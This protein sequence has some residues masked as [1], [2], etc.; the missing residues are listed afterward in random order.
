MW[1]ARSAARSP[2]E[3]CALSPGTDSGRDRGGPGRATP[4]WCGRSIGC[5]VRA[6]RPGV[7]GAA[8]PGV[9]GAA[10]PGVSG[11]AWPGVSGAAWPGGIREAVSRGVHLG[12]RPAVGAPVCTVV[13]S[14]RGSCRT[15]WPWPRLRTGQPSL[16]DGPRG[17]ALRGP[18][19]EP[20]R[21]TQRTPPLAGQ[22]PH[23]PSA[24][25]CARSA[26]R[27]PPSRRRIQTAGDH[28]AGCAG[29][30]GAVHSSSLASHDRRSRPTTG[31]GEAAAQGTGAKPGS[32]FS[33]IAR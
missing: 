10:C 3:E 4:T 22:H 32:H 9:I 11:A 20:V 15:A 1:S 13:V 2:G 19:G 33:R 6:A 5:P 16:R 28:A 21:S 18:H 14:R 31:P 29:R 27:T 25:S 24:C 7:I 30:N 17:S 12:D 8:C 26:P 23:R